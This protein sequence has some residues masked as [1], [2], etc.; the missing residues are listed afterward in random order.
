LKSVAH[1]CLST[2]A[3][4]RILSQI[5]K[6]HYRTSGVVNCKFTSPDKYLSW[7]ES[8]RKYNCPAQ[9]LD[10]RARKHSNLPVQV[11]KLPS[12]RHMWEWLEALYPSAC[13]YTCTALQ[14]REI[15]CKQKLSERERV[16][17]LLFYW[18]PEPIWHAACSASLLT[19]ST[20]SQHHL[21]F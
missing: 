10:M 13:S 12:V 14:V 11:T 17:L 4:V 19:H 3:L 15:I 6:K 20:A 8:W 9:A 21:F 2:Y 1:T 18:Y 7:P 16:T 5:Q